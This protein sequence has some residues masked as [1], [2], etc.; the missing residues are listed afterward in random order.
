MKLLDHPWTLSVERGPAWLYL[1]PSLRTV[2]PGSTASD[3]G[4]VKIDLTDAT[5]FADRVWELMAQHLV[6]RVVV[7][8]DQ[9]SHMS[10]SLFDELVDLNRRIHHNQG[11]LRLCGMSVELEKEL[12]DRDSLRLFRQFASRQDAVIGNRLRKPHFSVGAAPD[13]KRVKSK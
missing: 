13:A 1:R 11:I 10:D 9:V 5:G 12:T 8:L 4:E 3:T 7:E 2:N 6:C